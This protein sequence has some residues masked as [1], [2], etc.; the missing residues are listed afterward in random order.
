MRVGCVTTYDARDARVF[1]GRGYQLCRALER[2]M[3]DFA[4]LGPLR[5]PKAFTLLAKA[6]MQWYRLI[7]GRPAYYP[8]R[9]T[10]LLRSYARQVSSKLDRTQVDLIIS[11]MSLGSQPIAYLDCRQPIV[12]W[13]DAT[14]VGAME[15][16]P[17]LGQEYVCRETVRDGL[18][19]ERAALEN[20][21]LAIYT[22]DWAARSALDNYPIEPSKVKVVPFG[23]N[24][25]CDRSLEDIR[26]LV[27]TRSTSRCKLIFVGG[28]WQRKGGEITAA[29]TRRLIETGL[30]AELTVVG[31]RPVLQG[32]APGSFKVLGHIDKSTKEGSN[33]LDALMAESH[34]LILPTR[35]D[36]SPY[37]ICEANSFGVPALVT[38]VGGVSTVVRDGLNGRTFSLDSS[39]DEYC[40]T[41]SEL[42]RDH[43]AYGELALSSFHE[44]QSRLNWPVA[45]AAVKKLAER[46]ARTV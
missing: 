28:D 42:F 34:F 21:S 29:V 22:S 25:E 9:D 46:L 26:A 8:E 35:A 2:Q 27:N 5:W 37:V 40:A 15:L 4:Y 30:D 19:N 24:L 3:N 14:L 23:A 45:A 7:L 17:E 11:P 36:A 44:F 20:C 13:T 6:K 43:S 10:I 39:I 32:L 1:G 41:I 18:R 31:C 16:Y 33:R 38:D 12:I